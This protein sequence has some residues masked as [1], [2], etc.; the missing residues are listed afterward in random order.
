MG[1]GIEDAPSADNTVEPL[2]CGRIHFLY[3]KLY[4]HAV[5]M[6]STTMT[7]KFQ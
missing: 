2:E 6:S 7:Y 1:P 3:D 4:A 5:P